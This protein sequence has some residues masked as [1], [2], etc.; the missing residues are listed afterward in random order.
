[1]KMTRDWRKSDER[2]QQRQFLMS[3][4]VRAGRVIYSDVY[5]F[6]DHAISQGYGETLQKKDLME[7]DSW[8]MRMY[9]EWKAAYDSIR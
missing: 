2:F 9:D 5:E 1:M 6:C 8:L 7:V 4:F 3:S